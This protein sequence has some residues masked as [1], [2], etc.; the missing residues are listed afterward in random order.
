MN[1]LYFLSTFPKLSESFILNEI[2]ELEHHRH[3]VAVCAIH[4]P[5]EEI[6]HEEFDDLDIPIHYTGNYAFSDLKK[7]ISSKVIKPRIL[8]QTVYHAPLDVHIGNLIRAKECIEFVDSLE[9]E[10][11]HFHSHFAKPSNFAAVYASNYFEVPFTITTH[12]ADIFSE[13]IEQSTVSLLR[14]ATR[15]ITISEYNRVYIQD[16]FTP[17]SPIDVVRAGIRPDKFTPTDN[18]D[19]HRILTISRFVEKKGLIDALEAVKYVTK[20]FPDLEYH[21]IGSGEMKPELIQKVDDLGLEENVEFLDNV[22]DHRLITEL[23]E[24]RCFLLPCM[25][26]ESGDRD[27]IPVVLMEAMAMKTPA[28][29]TT[30]SGIPELIDHGKNGILTEPRNPKASGDAITT[31]LEDDTMWETF[32]ERAREKVVEEFDIGKEAKKLEIIFRKSSYN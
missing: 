11:D 25:V 29:S 26:T 3:N 31:L 14:S 15:I 20:E 18:S 12:A 23:D 22:S 1:I 5:N 30:V 28:V 4:E 21:L 2:Y 7:I 13:P 8:K 17:G 16:Q 6:V 10:P 27:G 9:W 24:A 19:P 32:S